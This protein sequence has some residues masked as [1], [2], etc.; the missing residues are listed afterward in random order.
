MENDNTNGLSS[1]MNSPGM[2]QN[3]PSPS[4]YNFSNYG[5]GP[6][7]KK[8]WQNALSSVAN[9][10]PVVGPAIGSALTG[11]W[12]NQNAKKA[13]KDAEKRANAEYDRRLA[14]ERAYNSPSAM[15][16]RL[17][18]A[19]I[20][21]MAAYSQI[22][23]ATGGNN[24]SPP[25][26]SQ[27]TGAP[28]IAAGLANSLSSFVG[29]GKMVPDIKNIKSDT[30]L[31]TEQ[32]LTEKF[33]QRLTESETKSLDIQNAYESAVLEPSIERAYLALDEAGAYIRNLNA[34]TAVKLEEAMYVAAETG[35]TLL[36][37]TH[38]GV[39]IEESQSRIRLNIKN[40]DKIDKEI[41]TMD[42]SNIV[43]IFNALSNDEKWRLTLAA[44][45]YL[46]TGW[47]Q[48]E[49]RMQEDRQR[50]D[51]DMAE[52]NFDYN[53]RLMNREWWQ[54]LVRDSLGYWN[55]NRQNRLDREYDAEKERG[56]DRREYRREMTSALS[57]AV[58][59]L[60]VLASSGKFVI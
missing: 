49:E 16:A 57:S 23:G 15:A 22:A 47:Q 42:I 12:D 10:I 6:P 59:I 48:L 34:T 60:M 8:W 29:L 40:L 28:S 27:M 50:H 14:D 4:D 53:K 36:M 46:Q 5:G 58:H 32:A 52:R 19:G 33:R 41:E 44:D 17:R 9:L 35:L 31:R 43:N 56:S 24:M 7:K 2:T 30:L 38:E 45:T 21:P 37:A 55:N 25:T 11:I 20:N 51:K 18:E 1:M 26:Q 3:G 13:Q 54:S 39:K